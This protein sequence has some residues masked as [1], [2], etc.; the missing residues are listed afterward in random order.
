MLAAEAFS[1]GLLD[2]L[3]VYDHSLTAVDRRRVTI[4]RAAERTNRQQNYLVRNVTGSSWR[5]C[6][7]ESWIA[8]W[9]YFSAGARHTCARL[10]CPNEAQVGAHVRIQDRR[11]APIMY[12]VP[13]CKA[14]NH[15]RNGEPMYID[16]RT[17]LVK[18]NV[19]QTC[20]A[21]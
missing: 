13:L 20:M 17:H 4:E 12:I 5:K 2:L 15:C 8:H 11:M 21:C 6:C 10:G 7:C 3:S 14:C 18:A 16:R 9:S 19:A 1:R